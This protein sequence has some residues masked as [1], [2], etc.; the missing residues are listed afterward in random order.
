MSDKTLSP[1]N[2]PKKK[3]WTN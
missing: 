2:Q 1:S 3:S